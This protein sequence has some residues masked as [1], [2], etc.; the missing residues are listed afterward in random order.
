LAHPEKTTTNS[1]AADNLSIF[2]RYLICELKKPKRKNSLLGQN[3][4]IADWPVM[5]DLRPYLQLLHRQS[6]IEVGETPYFS[7]NLA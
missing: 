3:Q 1:S 5:A 7:P 2:I 4:S 6:H